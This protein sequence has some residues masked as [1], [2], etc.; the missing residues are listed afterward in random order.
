MSELANLTIKIKAKGDGPTFPEFDNAESLH[1][2]GMIIVEGG[3]GLG[4]TGVGFYLIDDK[5]NRYY[6]NTTGRIINAAA[7]AVRG[8]MQRFGDDPDKS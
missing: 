3:T 1:I 2:Q 6:A 8:A 5:G 4:R 7:S